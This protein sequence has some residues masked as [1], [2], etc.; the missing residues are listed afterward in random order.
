[1]HRHRRSHAGWAAGIL[2]IGSVL[3]V[4]GCGG[5]NGSADTTPTTQLDEADLSGLGVEI[6]HAVG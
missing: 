6:H 5:S 2:L 4:A 3:A 1:M